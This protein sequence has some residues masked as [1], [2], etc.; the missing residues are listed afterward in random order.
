MEFPDL[1]A[2]C[3]LKSCR[4]LDFL[5]VKCG[6]CGGLFCKEHYPYDKH[7]CT[8]PGL[9]DK[10]VPVCPLCGA[11]VPLRPGDSPDERVGRHIDTA[12][13]S[14][15]ALDLKGKIFVYECS[16]PSCKRREVVT[17]KCER[18]GLNFCLAHRNELD[19]DCRGPL[20][21]RRSR[22][23]LSAAGTA[24]IFRA[25]FSHSQS[26]QSKNNSYLP[27]NQAVTHPETSTDSV[28][29]RELQEEEDRQLA[30]A[31]SASLRD[32]TPPSQ[33][34]NTQR[35]DSSCVLS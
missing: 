11:I 1:G 31:I 6:G 3:A 28:L 22:G 9:K 7:S 14:K 24:A 5:P 2:H 13:R 25:V 19:H 18:C 21:S 12:C 29:A 30:L 10:Q 34:T 27:Q 32:S 4:R 20:S 15:P 17:C 23:R 8:N 33:P 16:I 35:R 26:S